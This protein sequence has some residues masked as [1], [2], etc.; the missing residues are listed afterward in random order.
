MQCLLAD[1]K[2]SLLRVYD[3]LC[4]LSLEHAEGPVEC[5]FLSARVAKTTPAPVVVWQ[6]QVAED[7]ALRFRCDW[8]RPLIDQGSGTGVA[9]VAGGASI[10]SGACAGG[11]GAAGHAAVQRKVRR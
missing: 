2:P 4:R 1:R 8:H 9:Y 7:W 10:Y 6:E 11:L 3:L 5:R